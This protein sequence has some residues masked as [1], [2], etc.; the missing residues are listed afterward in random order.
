MTSKD[1]YQILG[2]TPNA[3]EDEIKKAYKEAVK[4]YHPDRYQDN[5]L[6][7]VAEEKMAEINEAY[8][9]IMNMRRSGANSYDYGYSGSSYDVNYGAV[10]QMIQR[11][12]VTDADRDLDSV[13]ENS[14][15]AEWFFLKGSVCYS[16]GWLGEAAKYFDIAARMEPNNPEYNA[17]N[18]RMNMN[19]GGYMNGSRD[20]YGAPRAYRN[21]D[22]CSN[23]C[24]TL[25]IADCCCE[26]MGGDLIPCC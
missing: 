17:A 16:R 11:G 3:S 4:K 25:C 8:D 9:E 26:M 2:I 5:P 19:S 10:R 22:D 21:G 14:R 6:S 20:V 1:P 15:N 12:N 24:T 7:E 23:T 18:N 13:P